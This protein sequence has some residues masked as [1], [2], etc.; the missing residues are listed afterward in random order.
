MPREK[1]WDILGNDRISY[2]I[3]NM[4]YVGCMNPAYCGL[5][6]PT[7]DVHWKYY[8][9]MSLCVMIQICENVESGVP[10]CRI[11]SPIMNAGIRVREG[12]AAAVF[13]RSSVGSDAAA[14]V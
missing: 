8:L 3:S 5:Y 13:S 1:N 6:L 14:A 9:D 11:V 4:L 7:A 10:N 12:R 2:T